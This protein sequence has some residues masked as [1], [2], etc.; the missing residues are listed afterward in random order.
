MLAGTELLCPL[1]RV[2]PNRLDG[3]ESGSTLDEYSVRV[4]AGSSGAG[5]YKLRLLDRVREMGFARCRR[6]NR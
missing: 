1:F 6:L 4:R 3:N 2:I 5:S